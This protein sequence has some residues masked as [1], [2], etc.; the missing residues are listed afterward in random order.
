MFRIGLLVAA[1][2]FTSPALARKETVSD[3]WLRAHE[4][5]LAGDELAGRGSAT[6][7]EAIAA[8]YVATQFQAFGLEPAP[9]HNSYRQTAPIIRRRAMG[10][11]TLSADGVTLAGLTVLSA[12]GGG[13]GGPVTVVA[14]TAAPPTKAEVVVFTGP[15]EQALRGMRAF[16][17]A[18]AK[19]VILAESAETRKLATQLGGRLLLPIRLETSPAAPQF[20]VATLPAAAVA[21]LRPGV[22]V[23]VFVPFTEERTVTT[24]AIGYLPG[25]NRSL[26]LLLLTAHLDHL[27]VQPDGTVMHGAN[28]DAAGTSALLELARVLAAGSRLR[29]GILFVAY[30]SEEIG[31]LGSRWFAAH[32]PVPLARIAANL[33]FEMVGAQDPKFPRGALMM[34]GSERSTMFGILKKHGAL[35]ESDPYPEQ[36]FFERSDNYSLAQ[37]GVVAHTLAGWSVPPTYHQPTDTI[38][39]LD[40]DYMVRAISSLVGPIRSVANSNDAP[41][42]KPDGR[43]HE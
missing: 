24:N 38:A 41:R 39:A 42:W 11:P 1:L 33:E 21:A 35:V 9:G 29:R 18:G 30:G 5:F 34:T 37:T 27:G 22:V 17:A 43:P 12:V 6:R 36:R 32:P 23:E 25:T 15:T 20:A 4:Q 31:G 2:L 28:D 26:S 8:A 14:S 3:R 19:L 13:A 16:R 40:F 7:D 10:T